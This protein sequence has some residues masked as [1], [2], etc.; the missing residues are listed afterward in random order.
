MTLLSEKQSMLCI[1]IR[2]E[3]ITITRTLFFG[4][5]QVSY[6]LCEDDVC[7]HRAS[8]ILKSIS[9][10]NTYNIPVPSPLQKTPDT[11]R[12][13]STASLFLPVSLKTL[14]SGCTTEQRLLSTSVP[15]LAAVRSDD[16]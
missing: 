16:L 10:H 1:S 11:E 7:N 12:L 14:S 15:S 2:S 6:G 3:G 9:Q 4:P 5:F 13:L 8:D